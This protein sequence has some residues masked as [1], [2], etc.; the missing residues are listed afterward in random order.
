L[1]NFKLR[2]S[3]E[4]REVVSGN[5]ISYQFS[6]LSSRYLLAVFM[7]SLM[8]AATLGIEK[9]E[10]REVKSRFQDIQRFCTHYCAAFKL[11]DDV[12]DWKMDLK[13]ENYNF[14]TVILHA[15]NYIHGK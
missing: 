7:P 5:P 10:P 1:W 14:N 2:N 4:Y 15:L 12:R 6:K 8:A 11:A 9:Y 13:M 3:S